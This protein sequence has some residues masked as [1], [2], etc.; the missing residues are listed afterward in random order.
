[1]ANDNLFTRS[2]SFFLRADFTFSVRNSVLVRIARS[3]SYTHARARNEGENIFTLTSV[4]FVKEI[5][6]ILAMAF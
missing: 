4:L 5:V 6:I 1:M 2:F 3:L